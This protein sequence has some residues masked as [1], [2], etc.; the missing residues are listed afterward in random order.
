MKLPLSLADA[1]NSHRCEFLAW[2]QTCTTKKQLLQLCFF[3][4][5]VPASKFIFFTLIKTNSFQ[6]A[7]SKPTIY[8]ARISWIYTLP[9][10]NIAPKNGWLEYDP[11]LLGE[12]AYFQGLKPVSFRECIPS[13]P[14]NSQL[15]GHQVTRMTSQNLH[16]SHW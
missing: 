2:K 16:L 3:C 6:F 11:F 5:F 9:E 12:T 8:Y 15:S 13:F 10:T 14:R 1:S 7:W 4:V